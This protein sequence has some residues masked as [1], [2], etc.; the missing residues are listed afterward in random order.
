LDR[1][2]AVT[3]DD[4]VEL[5]DPALG[6]RL[7]QVLQGD[8][9]AALGKLGVTLPGLPAICR[10]TRSSSTTRNE[11]PAPGTEVNP[12][13][14]TGRDGPATGTGLPSSSYIARTRPNAS[15]A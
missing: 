6:Q 4:Q 14:S 10:A 7:V 5:L 2:R 9:A 12:R 15:P 13:T 11:S 3:L 1:A 8:P